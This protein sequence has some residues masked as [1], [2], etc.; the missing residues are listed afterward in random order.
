MERYLLTKRDLGKGNELQEEWIE[1]RLFPLMW[2]TSKKFLPFSVEECYNHCCINKVEDTIQRTKHVEI[3][4]KV[5]TE[6]TKLVSDA[7]NNC[8]NNYYKGHLLNLS[9]LKSEKTI[10]GKV[11][12]KHKIRKDNFS[13]L[14]REC[15]AFDEVSI[16]QFVSLNFPNKEMPIDI[17]GMI[18]LLKDERTLCKQHSKEKDKLEV[19]HP[20]LTNDHQKLL[21]DFICIPRLIQFL[22]MQ[23]PLD[24]GEYNELYHLNNCDN[25][26]NTK[27]LCHNGGWTFVVGDRAM[28]GATNIELF[29]VMAYKEEKDCYMLHVKE[30]GNASKARESCSQ[31]KIAASVIASEMIVD[32]ENNI[33]GR[34]FSIA[35][36]YKGNDV[37]RLLLKD[38]IKLH[39]LYFY[40]F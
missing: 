1:K 32:V 34:F 12:T 7:N 39:L 15:D 24:E 18:K 4:K 36:N 28:D 3:L 19:C 29:D 23:C 38:T 14:L 31:V 6:P 16:T 22:R 27:C 13:L 8:H 40:R 20:Y 25:L 37:H 10:G 35:N 30:G 17:K 21:K 33:F 5:L 11:L 2:N 9:S 26:C